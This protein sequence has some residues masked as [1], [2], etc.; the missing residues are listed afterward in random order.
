MPD[1]QPGSSLAAAD[2][3]GLTDGLW[4]QYFQTLHKDFESELEYQRIKPD[5]MSHTRPVELLNI[6]DS[7][8]EASL[9]NM[10][11]KQQTTFL[12]MK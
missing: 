5:S 11:R 12:F 6:S 9:M 10:G 2:D 7:F 1:S 8:L 4:P 3:S